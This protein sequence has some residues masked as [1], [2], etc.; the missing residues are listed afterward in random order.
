MALIHCACSPTFD[1]FGGYWIS[2]P[3]SF[4]ENQ[5]SS[6]FSPILISSRRFCRQSHLSAALNPGRW[7]KKEVFLSHQTIVPITKLA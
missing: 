3:I 4:I 5:V 1:E 2:L 6:T 7:M